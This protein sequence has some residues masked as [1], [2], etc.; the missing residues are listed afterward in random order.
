MTVKPNY[1]VNA[2]ETGVDIEVDLPGVSKEDVRLSAEE[3]F[4]KLSAVRNQA[5]PEGWQLINQSSKPSGYALE[6][7]MDAS[8]DLASIEARYEYAVLTLRIGKH[9][10]SLPREISIL[11]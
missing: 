10:D 8:L 11:N 1:K 2:S 4:L 5:T 9:K 7:E 6:L 3:E